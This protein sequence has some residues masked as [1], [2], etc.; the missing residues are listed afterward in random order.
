MKKGKLPK[1][2][3]DDESRRDVNRRSARQEKRHA[4]RTGGK[5]QPGS[6]SSYRAP[7]DVRGPLDGND[8]GFLD[9][10]KQYATGRITLTAAEWLK[11]R[12]NARQVGREPRMIIE[13][14]EQEIALVITETE[15]T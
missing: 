12:K 8:E 14:P 15:P 6:G 3:G 2:F 4:E 10:L 5:V 9:Q 1:F 11:L 7:E 13:F